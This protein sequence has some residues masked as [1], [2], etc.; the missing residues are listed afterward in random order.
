MHEKQPI[1]AKKLALAMIKYTPASERTLSLFRTPFEQSLSP[2]N[3]W[4]RMAAVVPWDEMA[5]V[6]FVHMSADQGRASI[7]LRIVLGALLVKHIEGISDEDTIQYIQEN[8]YA[9]YFVGLPSFQ[10]RAVFSPTLFVEIRKRLG[11]V[12]VVHLNDLILRQAHDLG[13]IEHRAKPA[14]KK[15]N[16]DDEPP[17]DSGQ[18][19]ATTGEIAN[20]PSGKAV[21]KNKGTLKVDAT[22]APQHIGYPTDTRLLNDARQWCEEL[23]DKLYLQGALWSKKPRTYRRNARK[24]Y[25]AFAKKKKASKK[26][27]RKATS[28]QL[29]YVRR[30]LKH[31]HQMLDELEDAAIACPWTHYDWRR[32]WVIQELFR[33]QQ[34]MYKDGRRRVDDRIVNLA[35]PFVRPI[36]RG[37][38]GK[39]TEFGA[40]INVSETEGFARM[41]RIDFDNFNEGT[42]LIDQVEAYKLLYGYYPE[43]V[44]A[45]KIYLTRANRK[46]LKDNDIRNSGAPLGR[47]PQWSKH[48]K[49]KRRK[50]Q[51]KR[52]HI[53]G[54]FGQAKSK[55]G[56]DDIQTRRIDT[57]YACIGLILLALN[58]LKL[59][60]QAFYSFLEELKF[61]IGDLNYVFNRFTVQK[62]WSCHTDQHW[63]FNTP[64]ICLKRP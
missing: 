41:D 54:K 34:I 43:L 24:D 32:F 35:Q 26:K 42:G 5:K 17:S 2:D 16:K 28:Q 58:V 31:L 36:K 37:K 33:Q 64:P 51:N 6:F 45:D 3:R 63:N 62:R 19:E 38:A 12:G 10:T 1:L 7:D 47:K 57:S 48:E 30:N 50:E 60:Q 13:A 56:L 20:K 40:K 14:P 23:I 8:V 11:E 25:L 53:E 59:G 15:Q 9:Q 55:Y 27:I 4:V 52:A 18:G 49:D 29:N 44:L 61:I 21:N 46:Y 22:V 39:P